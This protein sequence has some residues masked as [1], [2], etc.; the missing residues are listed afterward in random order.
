VDEPG[1]LEVTRPGL[2]GSTQL[3]VQG[4][5]VRAVGAGL[6]AWE[7]EM[8]YNVQQDTFAARIVWERCDPLVVQ[9]SVSLEPS[10]REAHLSRR[11]REGCSRPTRRPSRRAARR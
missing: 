10:L 3:V 11:L 6:L 2:L 8:D 9:F 1:L 7:Q 4:G 5:C